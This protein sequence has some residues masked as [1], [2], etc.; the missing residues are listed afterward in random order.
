MRIA[1]VF[2]FT[3]LFFGSSQAQN[4]SR[5]I[6][7]HP[8]FSWTGSGFDQN[9]VRRKDS[10]NDLTKEQPWRFGYTYQT[11]ISI[12]D[13]PLVHTTPERLVWRYQITCPEALTVNL[14][15]EDFHLPEGATLTLLA[16]DGSNAVGPYTSANNREDGMLGS[17]LV[18]GESIIVEYTEPENAAFSGTFTIGS[19]I[20]G[21]RSLDIIEES[22]AKS[23]NDS[24]DCHY[25]VGCPLGNGWENE[26][27]SVAMIIVNGNGVCTGALINNACEDGRPLMLSANHC[28]TTNTANWAFR[29]NW[30]TQAGSE[31]CAAAGTSVDPGPPYDQTANGATVLANGSS[32]DF[33]LLELDNL[34]PTNILDWNLYFNGW[35]R[36]DIENVQ[37]GTVI[38]HPAGDVMKI[39]RESDAPYHSTLANTAVW[40]IDQYEMGSTEGGSSGAPL[41]NQDHRIVGQLYGGTA[42][43]SGTN[44]NGNSDYYGRLGI[45]WINGLDTLLAPD[46]CGSVLVMDGWEPDAPN[47]FDDANLQF[48]TSPGGEICDDTFTPEV[49]LRNAGDNDLTSCLIRY[50]IDGGTLQT[51]NW[52]GNLSPNGYEYVTLPQITETSGSHTFKAY[53]DNPNNV[54]DN[55]HVND[56]TEVAFSLVPNTVETHILIDTDCY[57]YET[58]WEIHDT[59][60]NLL[61]SGGNALVPPGGSQTALSSDPNSYGNENHIDE[62]LCLV[63]G[64]Y[65]FTIYDDWGDGLEG[66]A[67]FGCSV[68]G[69]YEIQDEVGTVGNLQNVNFGVSETI[70]IC[71]HKAGLSE[72]EPATFS[73]YPNPVSETLY[74]TA[75]SS[76]ITNGTTFTITDILGQVVKTGRLDASQIDVRNLVNGAYFIAI[77]GNSGQPVRFIVSHL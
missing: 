73:V 38:H 23:I 27:R 63:E 58:A 4:D 29:F 72:L 15:F 69:N 65:T 57:G 68:D 76:A 18:H 10:I 46:S 9:E 3:L 30:K 51:Y 20:H 66:S 17:E 2:W 77:S 49:I 36:S 71:V 55:N 45:A 21:Y 13:A 60:N 61:F 37:N 34:T 28:L 53:S 19:V 16:A 39:S 11:H 52:S 75:A 24:G 14:L 26:I 50:S 6:A 74:I 44:P 56:T 33:L 48:I 8:F 70:T 67:Q 62:Q 40:W 32:A 42:S 5:S 12:E 7:V 64:C 25:D 31:S 54:T 22:L 41:F 35:D 59:G 43:C 1:I 47:V